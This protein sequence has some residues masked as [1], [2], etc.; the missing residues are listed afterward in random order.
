MKSLAEAKKFLKENKVKYILAQFVDIHGVAKVKSVPAAHLEDIL[1]VGAGFAG[2][3][4]WGMGIAPN[5]PDYMAVGELSTLNLIPWQPGYA[6]IV[7][8]GHVMVSLMNMIR[9]SCLKSKSHALLKKVG[10]FIQG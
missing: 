9:A 1:T 7:C 2:G 5:G 4:I 10:R 6:R 3:A 8:D